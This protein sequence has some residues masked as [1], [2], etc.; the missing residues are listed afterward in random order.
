MPPERVPP[1]NVKVAV[2]LLRVAVCL[3]MLSTTRFTAPTGVPELAATVTDRVM[4]SSYEGDPLGEVTDN[5]EVVAVVMA[6]VPV[7]TTCCPEA[8]VALLLNVAVSVYVPSTVG[9]NVASKSQLDP[10]A[11]V[12]PLAQAPVSELNRLKSVVLPLVV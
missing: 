6:P 10:A 11:T 7:K 4:A 3:V 2:P 12:A 9:E 5:V 8:L 1:D